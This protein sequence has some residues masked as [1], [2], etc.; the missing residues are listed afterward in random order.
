MKDISVQELINSKEFIPVD[1]RAPIEHRDSA[2]PGSVNIPLFT[3]EERQEIGTL[4]KQSGEEAAKWRAMEIV[5]PK[6]PHLLGEI[7]D[8]KKSGAEPVVHCWRGGMRSRSVASFLEY[9]GIPALRLEGG[10]RAYREY[11]LERIPQLL[12]E[13][14]IV[15][16]GMTGTGKTEILQA[17]QKK[18]YP[19]VDLEKMANHR[20]SI[21]G[22]I[23]MGEAHNQKTFDAL[24]F[25]RLNEIKSTNYFII[26]AESKRIGRAAQP[27][28]ML[29]KKVNGIHY[30]VKSSIPKRV[31]RIYNEYV[32]PF[33]GE[34]WFEEE[35]REKVSKLIKRV[36]HDVSPSLAFALEEKNYKE[37]IEILLVHYYDPRYKHALQEY[38]GPFKEIDSDDPDVVEIIAIELQKTFSDSSVV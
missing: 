33:L 28:E 37:L 19:V 11:I 12:P 23:G 9:A 36:N 1:V 27:E 20:G 8:L 38:E 6:L 31:E 16:H 26:E 21:F 17:L 5:S 34:A 24:L 22:M 2:I 32:Q 15:L 18:G 25:E 35:V 13:K 30:L 4:Y 3:D 7:R 29:E 14:A 10:Y